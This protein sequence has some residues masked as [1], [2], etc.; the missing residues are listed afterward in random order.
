MA[1]QDDYIKTALRLP[2]E[3]HKRVQ[4]LADAN[5]R[6]MNAEIIARLQQSFE[7]QSGALSF[8]PMERLGDGP[9][10]VD[11]F[12]LVLDELHKVME[13]IRGFR[14]VELPPGTPVKSD[15]TALLRRLERIAGD[16][17][18]MAIATATPRTQGPT[19]KKFRPHVRKIVK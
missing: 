19:S 18:R 14:R 4:D 12:V 13:E 15:R 7:T 16:N 6:S 11:E 17:P 8:K 9:T 5:G 2:R 1:L 3:L 10:F